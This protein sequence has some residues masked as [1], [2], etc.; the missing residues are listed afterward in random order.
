MIM[1]LLT[2]IIIKVLIIIIIIV[3]GCGGKEVMVACVQQCPLSMRFL[4][5]SDL[6]HIVTV[7]QAPCNPV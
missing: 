5:P 2:I 6:Y 4:Q 1:P 7:C 3:Q